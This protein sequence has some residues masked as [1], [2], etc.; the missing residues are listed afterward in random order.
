[1]SENLYS[2]FG[3]GFIYCIG[4]FLMHAERTEPFLNENYGIWFNAAA[5]HLFELQIPKNLPTEF[6][7]KI[8][9]W[10]NQAIK[11]RLTDATQKDYE[12]SLTVAKEIL[13]EY[14]NFY[15]VDVIKGQYE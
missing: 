2:E 13:M 15:D 12:E 3:K 6:K 7:T 1:M 5:D 11:F 8:E 14:D 9:M 10:Q 4:L